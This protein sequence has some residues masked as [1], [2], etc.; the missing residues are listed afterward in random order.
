KHLDELFSQ[1]KQPVSQD[2]VAAVIVPHA[3]Y[4]FSGKVAAS[5]FNQ[6]PK[7]S[8]FDRVFLIGSSHRVA[9]NGASVYT[10]GDYLTPLGRVEVDREVAQKLVDSS[11]DISSDPNAHIDEH[12]LE[13]E[14]P[15]LQHHLQHP[16]KLVPVVMGPHDANGAPRV[17]KALEEW[18]RPGNLFVISTDFSHYPAYEDAEKV[19]ALTAEAILKNDPPELLTVLE[20][21][22]HLKIEGL[23]TSLC[24]WSSVLTLL[25]LTQ[26]KDNLRFEKIEYQNSGDTLLGDKDRVVGYN[27]I[28][29]FRAEQTKMEE[30]GFSLNREEQQWLVKRAHEALEAAV[31]DEVAKAPV[32]LFSENLEAP[33]G[34][35]VSLYNKGKLRGCI[36]NFGSDAPLWRVIDRMTADAALNDS[37]FLPV[38]DDEAGQLDIEISVLTPKRKVEDVGEIVPGK[39]GIY[40]E[41]DGRSGTFLPQVAEKTGWNLE[42]FLGHCARDKAGI[43]WDGWKDADVYIYE[44]LVFGDKK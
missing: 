11:S 22:R 35:F 37:R 5:G 3:G 29:V 1:A 23:S 40:I 41:K 30:S 39:H 12:S 44:A 24:G 25:H 10:Q 15:F 31:N 13:V 27:A 2:E 7:D 19:D 17:A 20:K 34:A 4:V 18:F 26:N 21:N 32:L 14:L 8:K 33:V 38:T 42:E 9:F 6:I 36:G 28:A 16:F 43:G